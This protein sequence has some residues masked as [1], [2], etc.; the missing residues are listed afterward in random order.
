MPQFQYVHCYIYWILQ[1]IPGA[2]LEII[3]C[4]G[5]LADGNK[6]YGIFIC[7]QFLNHMKEID[8]GKK[9]SDIVMFDGTSNVQ[10]GGRNLKVYYPKLTVMHGV[11][12]TVSLFFSDVSRITIVNQMISAHKM[13][14]IIFLVLVYITSLIPYLN[15]NIKIS[16]IETLVFISKIILG[17][18]DIS[19]E[20]RETC[21]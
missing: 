17:W 19:L 3:D 5:H 14:Y 13:I 18:V 6:K 21:I 1:K 15:I 2:V 16:T 12:H 10:I 7:N 11:E 20:R 8:P 4:Q 9:L